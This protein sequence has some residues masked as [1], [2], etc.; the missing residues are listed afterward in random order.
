MSATP[1]SGPFQVTSEPR[2]QDS[3]STGDKDRR[4]HQLA[5]NPGW[6]PQDGAIAAVNEERCG[7]E[8]VIFSIGTRV[9]YP[10]L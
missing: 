7:N 4:N 2:I 3:F 8:H 5:P 6:T 9:I 10:S 1:N